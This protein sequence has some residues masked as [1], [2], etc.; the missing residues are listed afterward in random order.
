MDLRGFL[1]YKS[2]KTKLGW[3]VKAL[4]KIILKN[5]DMIS[6]RYLKPIMCL[7]ALN[8]SITFINITRNSYETKVSISYA[9]VP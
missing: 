8:I 1:P 2:A 3:V 6:S 9:M 7:L 5:D 4:R